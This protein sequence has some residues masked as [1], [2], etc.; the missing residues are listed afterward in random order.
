MISNADCIVVV[1]GNVPLRQLCSRLAS[2]RLIRYPVFQI[3]RHRD[4]DFASLLG[5]VRKIGEKRCRVCLSVRPSVRPHGT[6]RLPLDR[7]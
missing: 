7:F 6:T 4:M 1:T 2:F 5:R 3:P